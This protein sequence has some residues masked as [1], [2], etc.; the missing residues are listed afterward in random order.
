MSSDEHW[1]DAE[2]QLNDQT[3]YRFGVDYKTDSNRPFSPAQR[4]STENAR[5][6]VIDAIVND[7]RRADALSKQSAN[8]APYQQSLSAVRRAGPTYPQADLTQN[9]ASSLADHFQQQPSFNTS[10]AAPQPSFVQSDAFYTPDMPT[11]VQYWTSSSSSSTA[12]PS[13]HG[14]NNSSSTQLASGSRG[15]ANRRRQ[16]TRAKIA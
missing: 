4:V 11:P 15:H 6:N 1:S 9:V 12:F 16:C 13:L 5:E 14:S 3:L 10:V 8:M 7:P 2:A